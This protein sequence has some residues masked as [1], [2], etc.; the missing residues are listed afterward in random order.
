MEK[1]SHSMFARAMLSVV[2]I[3]TQI[4]APWLLITLKWNT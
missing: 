4:L 3:L 2:R 1:P